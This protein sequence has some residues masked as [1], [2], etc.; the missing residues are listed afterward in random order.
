[1]PQGVLLDKDFAEDLR[2]LNKDYLRQ[3]DSTRPRRLNFINDEQSTSANGVDYYVIVSLNGIVA[4]GNGMGAKITIVNGV[5]SISATPTT[6]YS[7]NVEVNAQELGQSYG[8]GQIVI[9]SGNTIIGGMT[10]IAEV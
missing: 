6:L 2:K 8:E 10:V 3:S 5:S 7:P 1:M 9:V 4:G